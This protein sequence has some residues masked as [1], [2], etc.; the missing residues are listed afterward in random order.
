MEGLG[1]AA[2]SQ[3]TLDVASCVW[4]S[5]GH[6]GLPWVWQG[7]EEVADPGART[8]RGEAFHLYSKVERA[9]ERLL[10]CLA[11]YFFLESPPV[12]LKGNMFGNPCFIGYCFLLSAFHPLTDLIG[13]LSKVRHSHLHFCLHVDSREPNS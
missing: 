10:A 3:R 11:F 7:R 2:W 4:A 13:V 8:C 12:S 6:G 5:T 9:V 1:K